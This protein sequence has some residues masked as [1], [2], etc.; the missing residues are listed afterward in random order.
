MLLRDLE[1]G[2]YMSNLDI[3]EMFLNFM[4]EEECQ[5]LAGVDL[6]HYIEKGNEQEEEQEI[7][8]FRE[9]V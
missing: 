7:W 9:G 2:T 6:T 1:L 3:A 5:R 8:H 4:L